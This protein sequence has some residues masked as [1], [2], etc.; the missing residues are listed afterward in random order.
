MKEKKC[1]YDPGML[2]Q[3]SER[4]GQGPLLNDRTTT[5]SNDLLYNNKA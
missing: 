3:T 5:I 1:R 2:V 4:L